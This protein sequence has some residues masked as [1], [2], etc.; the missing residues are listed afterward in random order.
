MPPTGRYGSSAICAGQQQR[1]TLK[2]CKDSVKLP[3]R[4][5]AEYVKI[6][7]MTLQAMRRSSILSEVCNTTAWTWAEISKKLAVSL[8]CCL[9]ITLQQHVDLFFIQSVRT[10]LTC[11]WT[12][13]T[14]HLVFLLFHRLQILHRYTSVEKGKGKHLEL[15]KLYII[16]GNYHWMMVWILIF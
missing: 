16:G 2:N 9:K 12:Q 13:V 11:C 4:W 3:R 15:L 5:Q 10:L 7:H 14:W 6:K 8:G 1:S